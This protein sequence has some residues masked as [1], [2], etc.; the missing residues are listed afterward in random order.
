HVPAGQRALVERLGGVARTV[1]TTDYPRVHM[2]YEDDELPVAGGLA[3]LAPLVPPRAEAS[4]GPTGLLQLT[5]D[6]PGAAPAAGRVAA[7]LQNAVGWDG[8]TA[9]DGFRGP[10]YGG[11]VNR[12]QRRPG[13]VAVLLDNP[14][15]PPAAGQLALAALAPDAEP[16]PCWTDPAQ[17]AAF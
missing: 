2:R 13:R 3:A 5:V 17:L 6:H 7:T 10:G 9:L 8:L 15:L 14:S 4:G 16:Y 11:N 1:V 12:V